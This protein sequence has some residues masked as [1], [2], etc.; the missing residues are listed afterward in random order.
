MAA[1]MAGAGGFVIKDVTGFDLIAAVRT[2]GWTS[3][4]TVDQPLDAP[5][6]SG[7]SSGAIGGTRCVGQGKHQPGWSWRGWSR[8]V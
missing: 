2:V 3:G 4:T 6:T 5:T 1:F 7:V 8:S